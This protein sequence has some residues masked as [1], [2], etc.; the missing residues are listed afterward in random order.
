MLLYNTTEGPLLRTQ[1]QYFRVPEQN[2]DV[3]FNHEALLPYLKSCSRHAVPASEAEAHCRMRPPIGSQEVWAAGVTY[4]RSR[5][6]RMTESRESGGSDFYDRVYDS[7][8]PEL[9]LKATPHR[10]VGPRGALHLRSDSRWIVPEPELTV[11]LNRRGEMIGY[12]IGNDLSCRDIEGENP[13]YLPQAKVFDRC[14]ALGPGLWV[15]DEPLS[16][17]TVIRLRIVRGAETVFDGQTDLGR[18]KRKPRELAGY[19]F[20]DNTFPDGCYLMTGTGVVPPDGFS[21]QSEDRVLIHIEP[22]GVLENTVA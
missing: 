13:L 11:A 2:W 17:E 6:A 21:L 10:V 19:L 7:E 12:T 1:D 20:R 9:F 15:T 4:M 18:L 3:L 14:A 22:I 5:E 8:R 16:E